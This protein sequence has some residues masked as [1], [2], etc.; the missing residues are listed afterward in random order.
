MRDA[1]AML[2][3]DKRKEF[4]GLRPHLIH[5]GYFVETCRSEAKLPP[6]LLG[7][8]YRSARLLGTAIFLLTPDTFSA[9]HKLPGD[10]LSHSYLG[11][12]VEMLQI[13]PEGTGQT[14]LLGQDLEAR[15]L[16]QHNVSGEHW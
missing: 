5:G 3:V 12:P 14:L 2:T 15:M 4:L 13:A 6:S 11:D 8:A 1:K 10:E 16:L 7:P 9:V